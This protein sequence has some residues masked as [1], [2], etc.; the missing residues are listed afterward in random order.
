[1]LEEVPLFQLV[2]EEVFQTD[3]TGSSDCSAPPP[4]AAK[5]VFKLSRFSPEEKEE[6]SRS[7]LTKYQLPPVEV[8]DV[9]R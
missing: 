6:R 3:D 1:M 7:R 4:R 9:P 8:F 2:V 5:R